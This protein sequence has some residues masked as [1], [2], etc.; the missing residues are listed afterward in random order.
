LCVDAKKLDGVP[1]LKPGDLVTWVSASIP[2]HQ[3]LCGIITEKVLPEYD[4][5]KSAWVKG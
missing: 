4:I 2:P 5:E 1:I 3:Y